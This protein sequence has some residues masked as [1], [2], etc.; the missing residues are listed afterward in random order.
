[1]FSMT[2]SLTTPQ[3]SV[4]RYLEERDASGAAPPTYREICRHF[5]YK[6]TKAA[7]DHI[8]ALIR[9]GLVTR[10]KRCA[11]GLRLVQ[12]NSGI[13]IIG[14]IAAGSPREALSHFERLLPINATAYGI[15]D[16]SKAFA[17]V[18]SGDS[19]IG[20]NIFERDIV[21]LEHGLIPNN[22]D[23]VAALIDNECTLKTLIRKNGAVWLQAENPRYP[24]LIPAVDLEIQGVGR[25][26]IRF[27]R[28]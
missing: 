24:D 22:G 8:E 23:V 19:M 2:A 11:R 14:R 28:K 16:V 7:A 13:P 1:M 18:V 17:L 20:R 21:L 5:G 10:E 25:A 15:A 3:A 9:K 4:L 6:S 27:I 26:V 12:G